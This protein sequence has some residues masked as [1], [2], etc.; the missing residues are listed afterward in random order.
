[1]LR[2]REIRRALIACLLVTAL[3]TVATYLVTRSIM[4]D[5]L[6]G[7]RIATASINEAASM[8][9]SGASVAS[10][11]LFAAICTFVTG[12]IVTVIFMILTDRRYRALAKMAANLDRVLAGERDIRL[13]DMS[14]G[15]LAILSS[16][17][18]KVIA[19]LN[20]TVDELQAEKLALSDALADISHQLKTPLT[21]IAIS[22]EL[23]RDR[24]SARG[25]SEDLVERLRLIQTLQARVEDLV[26]ALLKLARIDAGVIKLVCGAVDARELVRKSFEPLAIA[27]DIAD[28]RFSADVQDG[29]SYEGDLT[30]SV[31]AL[32]NI[33]KNC[34]E[35]TPAGGCVSVRVTE[36]VLACRIRIEDTGPGIAES[37]LPHIFERFYRGSRDANAAPSEVNPAGVGIGLAL[38]KSLVTAQGGTLTAEN[39]RDENGNVTGAA[40]NLVFFK[41]VV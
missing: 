2:N 36:D 22:T 10:A 24:L 25:D 31:E 7:A 40:F 26:A 32:E 34:M 1:M 38:S 41:T 33:L 9:T 17:I 8:V 14:E 3:G 18:D 30:W 19:R 37:D 20:L 12:L 23:I 35:H 13:R 6:G 27:F 11:A 4:L 5:A 15:E 29:A 28:V 16:E 39:L 21:S